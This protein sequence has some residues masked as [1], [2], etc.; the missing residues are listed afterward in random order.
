MEQVL[1]AKEPEQ[2]LY[3][4]QVWTLHPRKSDNCEHVVKCRQAPS[5]Y[6]VQA[7]SADQRL[8]H[9]KHKWATYLL[10]RLHYQPA[11]AQ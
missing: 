6:S 1:V 9:L 10:C 4:N 2:V 7:A 8:V 5:G 11:A 3:L